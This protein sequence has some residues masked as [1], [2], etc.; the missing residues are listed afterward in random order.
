MAK[1]VSM[2]KKD[3]NFLSGLPLASFLQI[4][5][6]DRQT[7]TLIVS[8]EDKKRILFIKECE[9]IDAKEDDNSGIDAANNILSW[10]EA[11]I[12]ITDLEERPRKIDTPNANHPSGDRESGSALANTPQQLAESRPE[13]HEIEAIPPYREVSIN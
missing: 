13:S 10:K 8:A 7:C 6:Q 4:L 3:G 11:T 9:I 1:I 2:Q 12:E 5:D